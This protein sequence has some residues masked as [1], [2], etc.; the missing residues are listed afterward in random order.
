MKAS[1]LILKLQA[2][3]AEHGDLEVRSRETEFIFDTFAIEQVKIAPDR[4]YGVSL[5]VGRADPATGPFI[6]IDW[7]VAKLK[8]MS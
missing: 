1:E 3:A 8:T 7:E 6:L 4:F 2:I 5:G